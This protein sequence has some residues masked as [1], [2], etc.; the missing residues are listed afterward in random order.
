MQIDSTARQSPFVVAFQRAGIKGSYNLLEFF[1]RSTILLLS[2]TLHRQ[3][4]CHHQRFLVCQYLYI[5]V[6][7]NPLRSGCAEPGTHDLCDMYRKW[8]TVGRSHDRRQSFLAPS[9]PCL[10]VIFVR[11]CCRSWRS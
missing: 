2:F 11:V 5:L 8:C 1:C 10:D 4:H 3:R 6:V 7:S 9:L